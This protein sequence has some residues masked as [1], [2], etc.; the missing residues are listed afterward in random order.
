MTNLV[1]RYSLRYLDSLA[2][3]RA[4]RILL[5]ILLF[6]GASPLITLR[7]GQYIAGGVAI[8]ILYLRSR[9]LVFKFRSFCELTVLLSICICYG[10]FIDY[11]NSQT[12]NFLNIKIGIAILAGF[13]TASGIAK[14]ELFNAIEKLVILALIIGL[15][16]WVIALYRPEIIQLLPTYW[17]NGVEHRTLGIINFLWDGHK[18]ITRFTG[19][20]IEP[21]YMVFFTLIALWNRLRKAHSLRSW[22]SWLMV[23]A[24]FASQSTAGLILLPIVL[25]DTLKLRK[26]VLY[27][28]I[29]GIFFGTLLLQIIIYQ[30]EYK[31][32]GSSSF[33]IRIKPYN[34]FFNAPWHEMLFGLGNYFLS[35]SLTM[36]GLIGWDSALRFAQTYGLI[37]LLI[38]LGLLVEA[39]RKYVCVS[40]LAIGA[41]FSQSI[42][43]NPI[44]ILLYFSEKNHSA[45]RA[46][47][48][49]R[50]MSRRIAARYGRPIVRP[51]VLGA[52]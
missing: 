14:E 24:I 23:V 7:Q 6:T 43:L 17:F 5:M 31:L 42:W 27:I 13:L 30:L 12:F 1:N 36:T 2:H 10:L 34:F 18:Y 26:L 46:L 51:P 35:N 28:F 16:I 40:V 29:A 52:L 38:L 22:Q 41:L 49:A 9:S 19:F 48:D 50:G 21:G 32:F 33:A 45:R 25:W 44:F 4:I 11:I 47:I 20:G 15:P 39:N 3:K 8:T 37:N